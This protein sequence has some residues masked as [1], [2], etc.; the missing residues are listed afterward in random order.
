M[1]ILGSLEL[2]L[3]IIEL[4]GSSSQL[5]L[6]LLA[7]L[8]ELSLSIRCSQQIVIDRSDT[9]LRI[10]VFSLP[11]LGKF[12][13]SGDLVQ[14]LRPVLLQLLHL[15]LHVVDVF[16]NLVGGVALLS[17]FT[18]GVVNLRIFSVNLFSICCQ[19]LLHVLVLTVFL[20]KHE[21]QIVK[22]L[23]ERMNGHL[24]CIMLGFE[25]VFL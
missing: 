12:L 5:E 2:L 10:L 13:L 24:V 1:L 23:F 3:E 14:V 22:L 25:V 8:L 6:F 15:V 20:S 16:S 7:L 19:V 4:L 11:V 18:L 9:L 21:P 17:N